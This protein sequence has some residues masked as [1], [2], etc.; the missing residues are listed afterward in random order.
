MAGIAP[1]KARKSTPKKVCHCTGFPV[2]APASASHNRKIRT[3]GIEFF[4]PVS[5]MVAMPKTGRRTFSRPAKRIFLKK[6]FQLAV[7]SVL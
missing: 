2:F 6:S 5:Q 4:V 7:A 3:E 1:A